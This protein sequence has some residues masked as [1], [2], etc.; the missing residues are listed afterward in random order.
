VAPRI[1][2]LFIALFPFRTAEHRAG[3]PLRGN[4]DEDVRA[5]QRSARA[6]WGARGVLARVKRA[7][8]ALASG[9][10]AEHGAPRLEGG[11]MKR[12]IV[13]G[14]SLGGLFAGCNLLRSGWDVTIIERSEER[15]ASRGAGLGVHPPMLQGLV[16]AGARVDAT[17]GVP[18]AG[19]VV[20]ARDGSEAGA[21]AM[22]QFVTSWARLYSLLSD[23]FPEERIRR[24]AALVGFAQD[25][26]GVTAHLADGAS[27]RGEVLVAADGLRSTVRQQLLPDVRFVYAGYVGWRGMAEEQAFSPATHAAMFRRFAFAIPEGEHI[28]GY[29]VPG[30]DDDLT[31]GRRRYNWV[32]YRPVDAERALPAMLTDA[33]GHLHA[34]GIAPQAIR[35]EVLDGLRA[36]A[37]A[38]LCPAWAEVVRITEQPLF[39]PI[40]DL[41]SPRLAFGRVALLGDAAFTARPHVA[42]GAIKAGHDA[43]VLAEALAAAPVERALER[44]DAIRRPAGAALVEESR[45]L[46]AYLEGKL[47]RVE[48]DPFAVMRDNG[49]VEPATLGDDGGLFVRLLAE[50][51]YA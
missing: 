14:G 49:G 38:L 5:P 11:R 31:P 19:R 43:M 6:Y 10:G 45:R 26:G 36:D 42:R 4:A 7:G 47:G 23:V 37:D 8:S 27:L 29:P 12:A 40:G 2:V 25:G 44:Y 1:R 39:Q 51:G 21:I 16:A 13:V 50:V 20:F 34:D 17:V 32:W 9:V 30:L 15:L 46:G 24:G 41:E 22:P 33:E 35:R 28:L 48:R 18:V 3:L